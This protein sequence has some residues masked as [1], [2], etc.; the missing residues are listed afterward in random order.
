MEQLSYGISSKPEVDIVSL[1]I[2]NYKKELFMSYNLH[3]SEKLQKQFIEKP[4]QECDPFKAM[5]IFVGL[6]ANYDKDIES[7]LPEIFS[8]L[9]DGVKW[10]GKH[11]VHHPFMLGN[12]HGD[13]KKYHKKFAEIGFTP[14]QADQVSFVEL[15]HVP[16]TGR[17]SLKPSDLSEEHL[18]RL[19]KIFDEGKAKYI[20]I[21]PK[22]IKVMRN[23]EVFSWLPRK[24]IR[25]DGNFSVLHE[26]NGQIIY[27]MY[28]LSCYGWQISRLDRQI[29]QL[30]RIVKK[31]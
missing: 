19:S 14:E 2:K 7:K 24:P 10:W 20:F 8:Y 29:E 6:D 15:L 22:V 12:Y 28:H 11:K 4:W 1:F 16:T 25:E 23:T 26:Q 9:D 31:L 30:R 5:F 18:E 3:P 27:R 21:S 17:S 13:G